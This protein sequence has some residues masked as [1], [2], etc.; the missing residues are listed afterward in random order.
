MPIFRIKPTI[1]NSNAKRA[2]L[3]ICKLGVFC[4][5][6]LKLDL[7]L[8]KLGEK[9]DVL[10]MTGTKCMTK[11]YRLCPFTTHVQHVLK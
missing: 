10:L 4:L 6:N 5:R 3:N 2:Y 9:A 11:F 1:N 7:I 8:E